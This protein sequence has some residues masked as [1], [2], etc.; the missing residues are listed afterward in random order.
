MATVMSAQESEDVE[1][2]SKNLVRELIGEESATLRDQLSITLN[3]IALPTHRQS[4]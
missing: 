3:L 1:Q 2:H 4:L